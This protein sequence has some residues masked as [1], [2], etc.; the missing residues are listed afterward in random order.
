MNPLNF[1]R[2]WQLHKLAEDA[3]WKEVYISDPGQT[4]VSY[5]L[6]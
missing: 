6:S 1:V 5:Q 3:D 4:I 2:Y